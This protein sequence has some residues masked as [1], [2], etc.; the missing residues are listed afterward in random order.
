MTLGVPRNIVMAFSE[1]DTGLTNSSPHLLIWAVH[2]FIISLPFQGFS[3]LNVADR[4][5]APVSWLAA[6][7]MSCVFILQRSGSVRLGRSGS[8]AILF[9]YTALL[10]IFS[11]LDASQSQ[12]IDFA[13][14]AIQLL[15]SFAIFMILSSLPFTEKELRAAVRVWV[16]TAFVVSLYG[17]YQLFARI[18][19]LPLARMELT[20]PSIAL[21]RNEARYIEGYYQ[22]ESVLS[23]PSYLGAYLLGPIVITLVFLL[24]C[25][26]DYRIVKSPA[27][28]GMILLVL[29]FAFFLTGSQAAYISLFLTLA[30]MFF[31]GLV[32]RL[33]L[34]KVFLL[35]LAVFVVIG[36]LLEIHDIGFLRAFLVRTEYL[37]LNILD[38]ARTVE[39]TSVKVRSEA[40]YE[41]LQ[42]WASS[43]FL[44]VGLNNMRYYTEGYEFSLG[45]WQL[46]ADQGLIGMAALMF[47]FFSLF[48][49]LGRVG[50]ESG[51]A[52]FWAG[53]SIS[54]IFLLVSDMINSLF[55]WNWV[56]LQRWFSLGMA[57]LIAI[58]AGKLLR[59]NTA[60]QP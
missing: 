56:D 60:H 42:V 12:L 43:P 31:T 16:I 47:V 19:D 9:V 57:N 58:R 52:P 4:G 21:D 48:R 37:V 11:L 30:S 27:V 39:I 28:G 51:L 3:I 15:F 25:K 23:E 49:T 29:L 50:N 10:G 46:L 38:P 6:L 55:T 18:Y 41:A 14:K 7:L 17:I 22:V 53:I 44:G 2:L 35:F 40:I 8:Y 36:A 1:H 59:R 54:L 34:A 13:T 26:A 45:W 20:N 32:P 33:K 5:V 24:R